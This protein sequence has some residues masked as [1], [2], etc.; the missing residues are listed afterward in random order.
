MFSYSFAQNVITL[1]PDGLQGKDALIG[2]NPNANY[3]ETADFIANTWTC[4]G[5]LCIWRSLIEFDL[6]QIPSNATIENATLS[7]CAKINSTNGYPGYP[8]YGNNNAAWL[9]RVLEPWE[10]NTVTWNNQPAVSNV[11][12]VTVPQSTST[13][14]DYELDVT[15]LVKDMIQF[16]NYGFMLL[17]KNETTPY[18]SLIFSSSDDADPTMRPKLTITYSVRTSVNDINATAPN[19]SVYPNPMQQYISVNVGGIE[20]KEYQFRVS[21]IIGQHIQTITGTTGTTLKV[22]RANLSTGLY[23]YEVIMNDER[24]KQG[25]FVVQ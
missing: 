7:L 3:S 21:N 5:I 20:G 13:Q 9:R 4:N 25:K 16:N 23:L 8:T 11:N 14:Q 22:D 6:S 15:E 10:E 2:H 19:V 17:E 24:V 12:Q 1:Q 18:N